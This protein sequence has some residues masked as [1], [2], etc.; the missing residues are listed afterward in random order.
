MTPQ[1]APERL[2]PWAYGAAAVGI[3]AS[4]AT[5]LL[6]MGRSPWCTCGSFAPWNG[7]AWGPENSQHLADPYTFTHLTHGLLLYLLCRLAS[8]RASGG[9]RF[10]L[11]VVA[12]SGWEVLENTEWVIDRYRAATMA[13]GYYGDSVIN[14]VGDILACIVGFAL[15]AVLPTRASILVAV[16]LELTLLL[17]IHD[18]LLLNLLMLLHPIEAVKQWQLGS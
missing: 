16:L 8:P 18:S 17:W 11:A 10:L 1:H 4:A 12:E 7:D 15:A 14:S 13:L 2:L 6:A 5:L 9:T 3:V